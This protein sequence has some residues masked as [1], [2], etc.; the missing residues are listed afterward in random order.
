MAYQEVKIVQD[1]H[2]TDMIIH[3]KQNRFFTEPLKKVP[4]MFKSVQRLKN[5]FLDVWNL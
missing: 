1:F 2:E 5:E 3:S 4:E